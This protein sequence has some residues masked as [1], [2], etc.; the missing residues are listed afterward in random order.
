MAMDS[1]V[2][3][4]NTGTGTSD[5]VVTDPGFTPKVII[6]WWV[7]RAGTVDAVGV[8]HIRTGFGAAASAA[9][10]FAINTFSEDALTTTDT[11][12]NYR[13]DFCVIR[14]A[15][16]T[17]T[18]DGAADL[19]TLDEL[20]FTL[21]VPE[22]FG[23]DMRVHYLALGGDSLTNVDINNFQNPAITGNAGV[24]GVGFQPDCVLFF[25]ISN[26]SA[27]SA[28]SAHRMASMGAAVSS[29][30][31]GV[32]GFRSRDNVATTDT[33]GYGIS[34]EVVASHYFSGGL[35]TRA[36]FVS[37]D[38]DGFTLNWLET[39]SQ[40]FHLYVAL[41]GG[42]Y[43][44]GNLLTK[45]DGTDIVES[46]FGFQPVAALFASVCHAE[47]TAD[48]EVSPSMFSLGAF[49]GAMERGVQGHHEV[50]AVGTS[51]CMTIIEHDAVYAK[52]NTSAAVDALMD[53]KS[54]DL[55]G[56]TCVMDDTEPTTG[57]FVWYVAF[58]S[59]AGGQP[60]LLRHS[61]SISPTG[62]QRF[63]RGMF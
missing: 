5:I 26:A 32:S 3:A 61:Y 4:F 48:T 52:I 36:D 49:S 53:I 18:R 56:F 23:V 19:K 34:S 15:L 50:D 2:G 40:F 22:A 38:I 63:G 41:K 27:P 35:R 7:G 58:G 8:D 25:N 6:F 28:G 21:D 45:T 33:T 12:T 31:R 59:T 42:N 54:I 11:G 60:T 29:S 13:T 37:M 20:G 9:S 16:T 43:T 10:R 39:G 44:V 1:F 47:D 57:S 55:D 62:A 24:T 46:S 51:D 14:S 17:N 30:Q